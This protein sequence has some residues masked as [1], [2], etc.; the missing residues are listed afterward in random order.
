MDRKHYMDELARRIERLCRASKE[1]YKSSAVER[2]RLEGFIQAGVFLG[3]TSNTETKSLL[4]NTYLTVFGKP[5]RD[6][7][8]ASSAALGVEM[9][10]YSQYDSPSFMRKGL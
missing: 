6:G 5:L 4:E 9:L 8:G 3:I 1:G 7:E 2:H 10:D